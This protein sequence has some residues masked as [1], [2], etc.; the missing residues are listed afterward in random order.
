MSENNYVK[1]FIVIL[2]LEWNSGFCRTLK[3]NFNEIIE[4]GAVKLD[5]NLETVDTFSEIVMQKF[6]MKFNPWVQELTH[7]SQWELNSAKENF[8][9]VYKKFGAFLGDAVLM[10]WGS[11]DLSVLSEN[12]RVHFGTAKPLFVKKYCNLQTYCA[13]ALN[14][15]DAS[16]QMGLSA[17]CEHMGIEIPEIP[18]HRAVN[19]AEV[20]AMCLK[21]VY[22]R[23][24]LD[25]QT[26]VTD[27]EFFRRMSFK[28]KYLRDLDNPLV[29]KSLIEMDCPVCGKKMT[30][31]SDLKFHNRVFR[32]DFSCDSCGEKRTAMF[33]Y[34]LCF[35][36][37][38]FKKKFLK[39][40]PVNEEE[41]QTE[42]KM[43]L[44]ATKLYQES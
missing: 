28:P 29:D 24:V 3:R 34:K 27:D 25:S 32:A 15:Y 38:K 42:R 36:G 41:P 6:N 2:D 5:S 37:V 19:D 23:D 20:S 12:C 44:A 40:A 31:T 16:K 39:P 9:T 14:M 30:R 35:D 11:T 7:I 1:D 22:N 33:V 17:A 21:A 10:T 43:K 26:A 13:K 18:L 8:K 4:I